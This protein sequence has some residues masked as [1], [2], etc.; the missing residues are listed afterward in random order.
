MSPELSLI[1][2]NKCYSSWS[3][4]PWLLLKYFEVDFGEISVA[5][6]TP[7][8][9][10]RITELSPNRRVPALH[11][12][13]LVIWDSL[14][15]CEY[16]NETR[17]NGRGWPVKRELRAIARSVCAE[18]H[19]GFQSLREQLPMN[20]RR[21]AREP[22]LLNEQCVKDIERIGTLWRELLGR[23][24]GPFLFGTFSIADCFYAP[25]A[26]RFRDYAISL[27]SA[28]R[29]Y[30]ENIYALP[31][32]QQWLQAARAEPNRLAKYESV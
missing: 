14:A 4:R 29:G 31:A 6:D 27:G 18:M 30:V 15:I 8:F 10:A 28:E 12:G 2:G 7:E 5:L 19:S 21:E 11:D 17:L 23:H 1:I 24:G 20:L 26:A 16:V 13:S 22:G 25:V 3:L 9:Y 32:M